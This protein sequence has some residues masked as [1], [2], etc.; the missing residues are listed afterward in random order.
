[1]SDVP[2][3]TRDGRD[4]VLRFDDD[5]QVTVH[6][7][8]GAQ[9]GYL[10]HREVDQEHYGSGTVYVTHIDMD[11]EWRRQGVM[12]EVIRL[13]AEEYQYTVFAR[14]NDGIER[15]DGSRLTGNGPAFFD[16]MEKASLV[17][18]LPY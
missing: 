7:P 8:T 18:R 16:A 9:I 15:E 2:F 1:M 13:L 4:V 6:S 10:V 5:E 17:G 11:A 12:S 14:A 3:R